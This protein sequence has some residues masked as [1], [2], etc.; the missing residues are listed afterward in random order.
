MTFHE[1]YWLVL[2]EQKCPVASHLPVWQGPV[3]LCHLK[4][5]WVGDYFS[6]VILAHH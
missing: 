1:A 5:F 6:C 2:E 3:L 4:L